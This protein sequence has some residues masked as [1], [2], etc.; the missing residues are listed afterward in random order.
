MKAHQY[1]LANQLF[2]KAGVF[3]KRKRD[4]FVYVQIGQQC[5]MLEKHTDL[6]SRI[7]EPSP[8]TGTDYAAFKQDGTFIGLYL[9]GDHVEQ[10][11][12]AG[13]ARTHDGADRTARYAQTQAVKDGLIAAPVPDIPNLDQVGGRLMA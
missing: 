7:V 3:S 10:S 1:D 6:S 8:R 9:P 11:R 2:R 4:V 5:T 13:A 12:L